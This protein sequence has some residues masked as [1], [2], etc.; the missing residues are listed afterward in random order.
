MKKKLSSAE[1]ET[2]GRLLTQ[3][4]FSAFREDRCETLCGD[5]SDRRFVRVP[6]KDFS[7]MAI[8]PSSRDDHG[9]VEAAAYCR[10]GRHLYDKGVAVPEIYACDSDSGIVL[11]ED[12]GD[13]LFH[14]V[15]QDASLGA[16]D[17]FTLYRQ[18]I[19]ALVSFQV[20]GRDGFDP[21][22][23]WDTQRYDRQLMLERE[24]GYFHKAYCRDFLDIH[25]RSGLSGE[26][27]RLAARAAAEPGDFLLHRDFQ[28]RNVM[29]KD[30]RV[31]IIDFQGARLGPL[32][33][34]LASLL[35]DPYA[36]LDAET[37]RELLSYY[38]TAASRFID[39]DRT[40][41]LDGYY[42][43]ALQRNLQILGA[44]A[45]LSRRKGKVFFR[46]YILPATLTLARRLAAPQGQPFAGLRQ[47]VAE[48]L[49]RLKKNHTELFEHGS[50]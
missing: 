14:A 30:G 2:I 11:C 16:A 45:F 4:G 36:A 41:F 28:S 1:L 39:I 3:V 47:V 38:M 46:Q 24:S 26:F 27:Q 21:R 12:L 15:I 40:A 23:C 18:I 35:I 17:L 29:I 49:T 43:I 37:Q 20:A 33:Y 13:T 22:F 8:I 48:A 9:K 19:D 50:N 44:F 34:D 10:I 5:G 42:Y 7:C 6:L 25:T 32:A 31:R